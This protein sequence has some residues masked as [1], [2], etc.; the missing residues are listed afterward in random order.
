MRVQET[1]YSWHSDSKVC[2][3]PQKAE[4]L[5]LAENPLTSTRFAELRPHSTSMA[6]KRTK[7]KGTVAPAQTKTPADGDRDANPT[8]ITLQQALA[9][10]DR[11]TPWSRSLPICKAL[12]QAE[13]QR[14]RADNT[15]NSTSK[16]NGPVVAAARPV[17]AAPVGPLSRESSATDDAKDALTLHPDSTLFEAP[18]APAPGAPSKDNAGVQKTFTSEVNEAKDTEAACPE[19][20]DSEVEGSL[21]ESAAAPE[22]APEGSSKEAVAAPEKACTLERDRAQLKIRIPIEEYPGYNFIG[23]LLG[24]R[25]A[26]LKHL[27]VSSKCRL[28]IRGRGSLRYHTAAVYDEKSRPMAL[29]VAVF[30]SLK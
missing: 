26:T 30:V 19:H 12:L 16:C 2:G 24:P 25:G 11:L 10:L 5:A 1:P 23:R 22:L 15:G 28:Y 13:I 20:W 4:E 6:R 18:G 21:K 14:L 8:P 29:H 9:E 7:P 3:I 27:E 17:Q